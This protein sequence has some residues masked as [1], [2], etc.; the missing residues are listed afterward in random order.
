[1]IMLFFVVNSCNSIASSFQPSV[2]ASASVSRTST[3]PA[4]ENGDPL[5][6]TKDVRGVDFSDSMLQAHDSAVGMAVHRMDRVAAMSESFSTSQAFPITKVKP[7]LS[8]PA[9]LVVSEDADQISLSVSKSGNAADYTEPKPL[10]SASCEYPVSGRRQRPLQPTYCADTRETVS[11]LEM[12]AF[13]STENA[14]IQPSGIS[15]DAG[16]CLMESMRADV[17]D[18]RKPS[19]TNAAASVTH[20]RFECNFTCCVLSAFVIC[21][22]NF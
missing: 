14:E 22:P 15:K 6:M 8:L 19:V 12:E 1:M 3:A 21:L 17:A 7:K 16:M 5:G 9:S 13:G 20:V 18:E 11:S 10:V 4:T 2:T